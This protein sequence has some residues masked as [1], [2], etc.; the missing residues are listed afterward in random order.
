MVNTTVL[1]L[2]FARGRGPIGMFE[3]A[4]KPPARELS[5]TCP[6]GS[7]NGEETVHRTFG[8]FSNF[9]QSVARWPFSCHE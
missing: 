7:A 6:W 9:R 5:L 1:S 8:L 3:S 4:A 2:A